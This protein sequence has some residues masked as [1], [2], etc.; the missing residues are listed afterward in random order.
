[1][2][3]TP[4]YEFSRRA[5]LAAAFAVGTSAVAACSRSEG[6]PRTASP[7]NER[8]PEHTVVAT[9]FNVGEAASADN[10]YISNTGTS[11]DSDATATFG[12]FDNPEDRSAE[13]LPANFAPNHNPFYFA[14]PA[15]EF[16]ENGII[17]GAREASPWAGEPVG[18]GRSLFKG[19]WIQVTRGDSTIYAQWLDCG[20]SDNPDGA[21]DYDYVFGPSG[22]R[23]K[24]RFGLK[25]GLDLSPAAAFNLGFGIAE[26]GAEVTWQFVDEADVPDGLWKQFPAIDNSTH[27]N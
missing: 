3:M 1:M 22:A 4:R 27:W 24:N 2:H 14:L 5:F 16:D 21:R 13:G 6:G 12:G 23:P 25:A 10:A 26:G 11:W 15:D 17:S 8:Y 7:E 18:D 9:V 19:R 20:P